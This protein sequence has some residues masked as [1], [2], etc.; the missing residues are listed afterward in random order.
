MNAVLFAVACAALAAC[1]FAAAI[2]L[3]HRS[4]RETSSSTTLGP[5]TALRVIRSP[6]WLTGT[7][8]AVTGSALHVVAL[9]SAPLVV[10]QPVGVLSLVLT[11]AL[12]ARGRAAPAPWLR[13]ALVA[14]C[15]G[16]VAF[17]VLAATTPSVSVAPHPGEVQVVVLVALIVAVLGLRTGGRTRCLVLATSAAMLFGLGSALI[18]VVATEVLG[19]GITVGAIG[20]A[21]ES[22]ALMLAGGWLLHQA[23]TSGPPAVVIAAT[24]VIDPLTAV[25][26]GIG[27]Y[28][29]AAGTDPLRAAAQVGCALL[30]VAGVIGLARHAPD[31]SRPVVGAGPPHPTGLRIL[32]GADTFPPDV[33][34]AANFADRLARGLARRGHDVHVVC[35]S[36]TAGETSRFDGEITVH[37]VAS[38]GTPFHP[39]FR[40]CTPWQVAR[41]VPRLLARIRPDV[42]HVQAH[43]AVGRGVLR[44]AA[45]QGVP[46]V[47][48]NH[49]MPENLLGY[50]PLPRVL[51]KPLT[52]WAW[53]DLVRVYRHVDVVT[54]PTPRAAQLLRDNGYPGI[55]RPISCGI[56]L[57]RC[58]AANV[59]SEGDLVVLFV[60]RLD[61]EKNIDELLRAVAVLPGVRAEIV[62]R[63]VCRDELVALAGEL[64]VSDRV[65][66][67][68]FVPDDE[69]T[70]VYR[71]CDVFCMPGTAELQSIATM[72]AMAAGLPVVAADA[73][74]LPHLVHEGV[75]GFLYRPGDVDGMA[76]A[77]SVLVRDPESRATMGKASRAL[78]GR[79]DLSNTLEAFE[80]VYADAI[81]TPHPEES[82]HDDPTRIE[83][84]SA[85]SP[86]AASR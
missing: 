83:S 22:G 64:G 15:A 21:A 80:N 75:N 52:R 44:T 48:T 54:T 57:D 6:R 7:A 58:A 20:L 69:L 50:G 4:V 47:A 17:V 8:L 74:A 42:V 3:Q 9:S 5:R 31:H 39:T 41:S 51:H 19:A 66:F 70:E 56:D 63:G 67:R 25:A 1:C 71:R 73:M 33:N 27:V 37:R 16:T 34:G 38:L 13:R 32:I 85:G 77:L 86:S 72:E 24:T 46:V 14:V 40:V 35:P 45:H 49:F 30:A 36:L 65:R 23:Y 68:G 61:R 43:F 26:V 2:H 79:H 81:G 82:D 76:A 18:R 53:R 28:G 11:V 12:G 29:E 84:S 55:A 78:I 60:G 59:P 62:G 10:V